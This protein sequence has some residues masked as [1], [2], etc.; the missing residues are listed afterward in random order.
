VGYFG[1]IRE[2]SKPRFLDEPSPETAAM[3]KALIG[4][5]ESSQRPLTH[6]R[7]DN[8]AN[9]NSPAGSSKV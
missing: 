5:G 8:H 9:R 1:F 7:T 4:D 3:V 2:S 6:V